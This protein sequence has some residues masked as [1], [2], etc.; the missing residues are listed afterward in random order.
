MWKVFIKLLFP[1]LLQRCRSALGLR[2]DSWRDEVMS[3]F[4]NGFLLTLCLVAGEAARHFSLPAS[5]TKTSISE[6]SPDVDYMVTIVAFAGSQQSLPISGQLTRESP[7]GKL[8]AVQPSTQAA[9]GSSNTP[10]AVTGRHNRKMVD[11][12]SGFLIPTE[13]LSFEIL[14]LMLLLKL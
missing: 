5:A 13:T 6:L 9:A 12:S 1:Q 4:P 2:F 14:L 3:Q 7:N 10:A 11:E 8:N